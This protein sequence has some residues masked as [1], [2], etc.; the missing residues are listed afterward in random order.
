MAGDTCFRQKLTRI[1]A[2]LARDNAHTECRPANLPARKIAG[3]WDGIGAKRILRFLEPTPIAAASLARS[4]GQKD[5]RRGRDLAI[6]FQYPGVKSQASIAECR[7]CRPTCCCG[8][9]HLLPGE[10][11]IGRACLAEAQEAAPSRS[12]FMS[13]GRSIFVQIRR[14]ACGKAPDYVIPGFSMMNSRTIRYWPWA[15]RWQGPI[16][17]SGGCAAGNPDVAMRLLFKPGDAGNI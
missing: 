6:R 15:C 9:Q 14:A 5:T 4:T 1:M 12:R 13:V 2:R 17:D 16:G 10:L 11:D 7:Q 8:F 3:A